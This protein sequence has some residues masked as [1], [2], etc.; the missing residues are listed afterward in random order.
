M[1]FAVLAGSFASFLGLW[2]LLLAKSERSGREGRV[3]R[4]VEHMGAS[5]PDA[6][7]MPARHRATGLSWLMAQPAELVKSVGLKSR[8]QRERLSLGLEFPR[9]LE[10]TALG[11]KA[12]LGFDQAFALYSRGFSTPL[13][14]MCNER[15]EVWE[16]GLITRENGLRDLAD[17]VGLPEFSRF[18]SLV[19]RSLSYG[20]SF[21]HLLTELAGDARKSYRAARQ[22]AVAKTPVKMLVPTAAMILPAMLILVLGPIVM[23]MTERMF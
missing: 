21:T 15:L 4:L 7:R 20:A 16:R 11:M 9:M 6:R 5:A 8:L 19:T 2:G 13:A 22:E 1:F 10:I 14:R 18:A 3:R 23:S 17:A 12:G